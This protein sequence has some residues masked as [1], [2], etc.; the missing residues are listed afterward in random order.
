M[1]KAKEAMAVRE[2]ALPAEVGAGVLGYLQKQAD[3]FY[4]PG[5]LTFKIVKELGLFIIQGQ[6]EET[7][8]FIEG[9][10]LS[11]ELT[12]AL[13]SFG[14][15]EELAIMD[16]W[17]NGRPVCSSR[18]NFGV[19]GQLVEPIGEGTPDI[20]SM[21]AKPIIECGYSCKH[22]AY[23]Q[24]GSARSG[25]GKLCK[26]S[27]RFLIWNPDNGQTGVLSVPPSSIRN[28]INYR[29]ALPGEQFSSVVTR[30]TLNPMERGSYKWSVAVF[31]AGKE[32]TNEMIAPLGKPV[33][34][35]GEP[36]MAIEALVAEFLNLD[37]SKD[38]D[39]DT[40]SNGG[41]DF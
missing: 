37:M 4:E 33:V 39:Y 19:S 30:I 3:K 26:E 38:V 21:L 2:D 36:L 17:T 24:F 18:N 8:P 23:N 6:Q 28:W 13:W 15:D 32:T 9:I 10:I 31:S 35:D 34:Y 1:A 40:T 25:S 27:R 11:V 29:V 12:R 7:F 41:G 5:F 16:G 14:T 20:I 22:C